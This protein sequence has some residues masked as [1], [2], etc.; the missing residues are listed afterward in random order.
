MYI[1]RMS[2]LVSTPCDLVY[3]LSVT[4]LREADS[5]CLSQQHTVHVPL[6]HNGLGHLDLLAALLLQGLQLS[7]GFLQ[8]L[9]QFTTPVTV[10][11]S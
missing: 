1:Y 8:T 10:H 11:L 7:L 4:L 9:L 6:P 3:L 2:C 5:S